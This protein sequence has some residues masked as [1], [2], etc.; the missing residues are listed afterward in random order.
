MWTSGTKCKDL[1]KILLL[2]YQGSPRLNVCWYS[3]NCKWI[4]ANNGIDCVEIMF[5]SICS[6]WLLCSCLHCYC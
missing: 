3:G 1:V 2:L 5:K 6:K 4:P